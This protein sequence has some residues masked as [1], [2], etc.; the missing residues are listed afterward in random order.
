M[1]LCVCGTLS[2]NLSLPQDLHEMSF[3]L[4]GHQFLFWP[5]QDMGLP[6]SEWALENRPHAMRFFPHETCMSLAKAEHGWASVLSSVHWESRATWC[7]GLFELW[8]SES[9]PYSKAHLSPKGAMAAVSLHSPSWPHCH[10]SS[11][12]PLQPLT[13]P[14]SCLASSSL[15][16]CTP[17]TACIRA[18]LILLWQNHKPDNSPRYSLAGSPSSPPQKR[19]KSQ[20]QPWAHVL[21]QLYYF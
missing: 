21:V 5:K 4:S 17:P 7:G 6:F 2:E 18:W 12:P 14:G 10:C 19:L 1:S 9:G 8:H 16:I 3:T 11:S 15:S 20:E 13:S